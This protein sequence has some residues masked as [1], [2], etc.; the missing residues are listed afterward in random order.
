MFLSLHTMSINPHFLFPME[1]LTFTFYFTV[2][3]YDVFIM[4]ELFPHINLIMGE[5]I[6]N[7]S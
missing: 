3:G 5:S 6:I 2:E 1:P 4:I 7:S